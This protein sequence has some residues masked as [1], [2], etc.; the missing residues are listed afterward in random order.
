MDYLFD[1]T[2]KCF[3]SLGIEQGEA[4]TTNSLICVDK[5]LASSASGI[6]LVIASIVT[7]SLSNKMYLALGRALLKWSWNDTHVLKVVGSNPSTTY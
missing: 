4:T 3:Q 7:T 2:E 5:C 1:P 6:T